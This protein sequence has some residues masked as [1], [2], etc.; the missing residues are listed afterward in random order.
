LAVIA[1]TWR[2]VSFTAGIQNGL[3][4]KDPYRNAESPEWW[5]D[6]NPYF[7]LAGR[8]PSDILA[9]FTYTAH[10][11]PNRIQQNWE[12]FALS[13]KYDGANGIGWLQPSVKAAAAVSGRD[14]VFLSVGIEP[15]MI[16]GRDVTLSLPIVLGSGFDNYYRS[17][18]DGFVSGSLVGSVPLRF[19]TPDYGN[20]RL[21]AGL[22][23]IVRDDN[24]EDIGKPFDDASNSVFYASIGVS[25]LY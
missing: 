15:H 21:N 3:S 2:G 6:A 1:D 5:Y 22:H 25:F 8:L 9:G 11:S 23:L 14:G 18:W 17:G 24:L 12:E 4:D 19:L 13:L 10:T 20:W 16:I 7:G